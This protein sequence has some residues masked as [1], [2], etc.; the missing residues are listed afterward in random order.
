MG[1]VIHIRPRIGAPVDWQAL[2]DFHWTPELLADYAERAAQL[3]RSYGHGRGRFE[4]L[5]PTSDGECA[6]CKR[7]GHRYVYGRLLLCRG[8]ADARRRVRGVL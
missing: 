1:D 5:H 6:D 3:A 7:I 8:C 2:D 4:P